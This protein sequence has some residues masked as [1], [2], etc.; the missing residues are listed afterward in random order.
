MLPPR[1]HFAISRDV[2]DF[3][4]RERDAAD[5]QWTEAKDAA[6]DPAKHQTVPRLKELSL[7][8]HL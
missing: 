7:A 5:S 3:R 1:R 6:Q 8:K 4:N 2:F